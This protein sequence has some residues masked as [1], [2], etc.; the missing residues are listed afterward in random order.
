[1]TAQRPS[2]QVP[3][4]PYTFVQ[5]APG[6]SPAMD[7]NDVGTVVGWW[8]GPPVSADPNSVSRGYLWTR[9]T[10]AQPMITD[11][12]VVNQFPRYTA[13]NDPTQSLRISAVGT[14]AGVACP[15]G[16]GVADFKAGTWSPAEGLFVLGSFDNNAQTSAG[17]GI[18]SAGQVVGFSW[19]G[20]YNNF[21]P[22]IWSAATGVQPLTGFN[23]VNG[24]AMAVNE[25]GTVVG[26]KGTG[27]RAVAF[28]W[29]ASDGQVDVPDLPNTATSLGY[30]INDGGVVVGRYT[31]TDQTHGVFRWSASVGVE[32]LAAPAGLAETL[33]INNAGEIV[34]TIIPPAGG[35]RVPYL[36]RN[37]T[38]TNINDLMP[39]G[40]GFT[41]QFVQ[42]INNKGWI[43][44]SGTN[45]GQTE[46]GQGFVLIPPNRVPIAEDGELQTDEDTTATAT[47]AASDADGDAL[48]F[49]IVSNGSKGTATITNHATGAF[50]YTPVANANG[51]D[52]FT[53]KAN[54]GTA[55]SNVA[56]I[57]V[58]IA[59]VNDAPSASN[60]SVLVNAGS[61][62]QGTLIGDDIDSA[63]L[64]YSIVINGSKGVVTIDDATTGAF[65]YAANPTAT[66]G[67]DSF[68]FKVSDGNLESA[69]AT[70][71]VTIAGQP[72]CASD[73]SPL[74]TV[75]GGVPKLNRKT[76][77]YTQTLTLKNADGAV[78]GPISFV[79]DGLSSNATL[80]GASGTTACTSPTGSP[81]VN[82]S[83]GSDAFFNPRERATI[84]LQFINPSQQPITYTSRVLA[85]AGSR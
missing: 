83:V 1:V 11:A 45:F 35:G 26:V 38:W 55:D 3:I 77:L 56:T 39:S 6:F 22:F 60:G 29:S 10:G 23:G 27:T 2:G 46:L 48:T 75:T 25:Y 5:I 8:D 7:V 49:S 59:P 17:A 78:I 37:G 82:V 51:P 71:T 79:L 43:V 74:V 44:G 14:V 33:D 80:S 57:A 84:T 53:V 81:Y 67:T 13:V 47:L 36:Y 32:D 73:I 58:T 19:G 76:G 65:T 50:S 85:G 21:G 30:S 20:G 9:D 72:T 28:V 63:S 54:D 24:Y 12:A 31:R 40:T 61:S 52:S 64:F 62:V 4:P 18:N 34:A 68:T 16:C 15:Q 69:A 70:I 41:L 42:A 66:D